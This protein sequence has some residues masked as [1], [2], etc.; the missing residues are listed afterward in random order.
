MFSSLHFSR[1]HFCVMAWLCVDGDMRGNPLLLLVALIL[2]RNLHLKFILL[3]SFLC[4]LL[5]LLNLSQ[6]DFVIPPLLGER[7]EIHLVLHLVSLHVKPHH[8]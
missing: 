4:S 2:N 6:C 3:L 1:S 7:R 8:I 5:F